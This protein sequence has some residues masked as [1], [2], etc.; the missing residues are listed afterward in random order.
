M[1]SDSSRTAACG[2]DARLFRSVTL[3]LALALCALVAACGG[4]GGGSSPPP[5]V[6]ITAQPTDVHV[7]AGA[8]ASFTVVASGSVTYQWQRL[9]S[10]SWND[11]SGATG[12]TLALGTVADADNAAQFRVN[13]AST[14]NAGNSVRSS[15]VTLTV[16]PLVV[17][18][19]I[20]AAPADTSAIEGL[21]A[22][23]SVTATGTAPS[24]Q[25][26]RSADG[27]T[28]VDI[29]GATSATLALPTTLSDDGTRV[30]VRVSNS[31]GTVFSAAVQLHV[32]P[33]PQSPR[34]TTQPA[35][36]SVTAGQAATFNA[37]ATGTPA[38]DLQ[39]MTSTD[40]GAHWTPIAGA[41]SGSYTTPAT[42]LSDDGHWFRADASN[43]TTTTSD[44]AR[45]TVT[46]APVAPT[47]TAQPA[48]VTVQFQQTLSVTATGTPTPR[49]QWQVSVDNGATFTNINNAV[50]ATL[51]LSPQS[52]AEDGRQFRVVVSN[53]AGSITSRA[54]TMSVV[55]YPQAQVTQRQA[56]RI[57]GTKPLHLTA[58][59]TGGHLHYV[60]QTHHVGGLR[61][62]V[63][64]DDTLAYDLPVDALA[65]TDGV[66]VTATNTAGSSIPSCTDIRTLRWT[67]IAPLPTSET[68]HA[69][70]WLDADTVL[71]GGGVGTILRSTDRGLTWTQVFD[72]GD[73]RWQLRAFG[74]HAGVTLAVGDDGMIARS[75]NGGIDWT[76]IHLLDNHAATGL[77]F[78]AAGVAIETSDSAG[79]GRVYSSPD[80]GVTWQEVS[81]PTGVESLYALA[82]NHADVALAVGV[83]GGV[84]RSTDGGVTW[85][86]AHTGA[87]NLFALAFASDTV[88]V[89]A[90]D[91]G[92]I[93]RSPDA[94]Q[95][96]T[97]VNSG[98]LNGITDIRFSS[99]TVGIASM[100]HGGT[101]RTT[102]G[103]QTWSPV[104]S[105]GAHQ[106]FAA[107][108]S[109]DGNTAVTVGEQGHIQRSTD[110]GLNFVDAVPANAP[111]LAAV[112][113]NGA[114]T[115]LAAGAAGIL[116]TLDGGSTWTVVAV[117]G[118]PLSSVAFATSTIAV[119][120]G[121]NGTLLRSTNGG[122]NWSALAPA[123]SAQV[124]AIAFASNGVALA[125]TASGLLRSTDS[126]ATWASV[127]SVSGNFA[128]VTF[129]DTNT[130]VAVTVDG[131]IYRS[132]NGGSTWTLATTRSFR[133]HAVAAAS[134]TVL[135]A[136]GEGGFISRSVDGG[137]TWTDATW[138]FPYSVSGIAFSSATTGVAVG[139][140]LVMR[141]SDGG[142]TWNNDWPIVDG[143]V[144][145]VAIS[146]GKAVAVGYYGLIMRSDAL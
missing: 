73:A 141:T 62:D 45:L 61:Q 68:L 91:S 67:A 4:G 145:G 70:S 12:P 126:G 124:N 108:F 139:N 75:T 54:A 33:T 29:S 76:D 28:W 78:N 37:V 31:M 16:D 114:G 85:T 137:V 132:T 3:W 34:F 125:G 113:F 79:F 52:L 36:A 49:Y 119:A 71:A 32:T 55:A 13:V 140:S 7:T 101:L 144:A 127:A 48:D 84:V 94:G 60:W 51:I 42:V 116:R 22:Y 38:P 106:Y 65:D 104:T 18:P 92:T 146:Q 21:A 77:A 8:S 10:G 128:G 72:D 82:I 122:A 56:V 103:G 64:G 134:A 20:V 43:A 1:S 26:Q 130:A 110:G 63:A 59:A 120:G 87:A 100:L 15:V 107:S 142:A 88:A 143:Y 86:A 102:D 27:T 105:D 109:P 23:F 112:A 44:P 93:W 83:H 136:G 46:A 47:I 81:L 121:A 24:I 129:A 111:N 57:P 6:T 14:G 99:A 89:A 117:S 58:T 50:Y 95:T 96:W 80:L 74:T 25:W 135:E 11:I 138:A 97:A 133:I 2:A 123:S 39:W 40:G 5:A 66:C 98:T 35:S 115:G 90:G 131:A 69:T 9:Q 17:A 19:V 41:A 53:S 30:R 118:A